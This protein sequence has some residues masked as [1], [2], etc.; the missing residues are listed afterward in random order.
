MQSS[1]LSPRVPSGPWP[2]GK[3]WHPRE[4]GVDV[5]K[6]PEHAKRPGLLVIAVSWKSLGDLEGTQDTEKGYK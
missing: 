1:P 4:A 3:A 2:L 5:Q 6:M